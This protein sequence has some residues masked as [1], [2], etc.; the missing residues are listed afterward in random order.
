M[1][2]HE[3]ENGFRGNVI[4]HISWKLP[5]GLPLSWWEAGGKLSS[6][7]V[8][9]SNIFFPCVYKSYFFVILVT[10]MGKKKHGLASPDDLAEVMIRKWQ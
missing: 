9:L 10:R 1:G 6:V 8:T 4:S 5:S 7:C 2:F 3:A